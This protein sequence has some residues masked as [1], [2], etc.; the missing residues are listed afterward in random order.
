MEKEFPKFNVI[1]LAIIFDT[2]KRKILIGRRENDPYL[3]DLS[4]CFPGGMA[5]HEEDIDK[6]LKKAIKEKTGYTIKNLGAIFA[7]T[8]P[9]KTDLLSV[10][11]FCECIEGEEKLG[12]DFKELKWVSPKELESHFTKSY[13]PKL[14]E[15]IDDL[16]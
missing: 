6:S 15:Y 9:E 16:E 10:Y 5:T 8:Y 1:G 3:K 13:H 11:F 14:K 12:E 2:S 4:W 7:K